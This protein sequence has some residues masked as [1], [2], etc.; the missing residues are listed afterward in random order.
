VPETRNQLRR[1]HAVRCADKWFTNA[2]GR[3]DNQAAARSSRRPTTLSASRSTRLASAVCLKVSPT[4]TRKFANE[5]AI[6][7]FEQTDRAARPWAT[8]ADQPERA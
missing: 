1:K 3:A 2:R 5:P 4:S 6:T 8:A 7:A